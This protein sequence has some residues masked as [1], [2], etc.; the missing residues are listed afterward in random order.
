[1]ISVPS[2]SS[3]TGEVT[4]I[5]FGNCPK[6]VPVDIPSTSSKDMETT[7]NTVAIDTT[8]NARRH[9]NSAIFSVNCAVE[10][11]ALK[12]FGLIESRRPQTAEELVE[13]IKS[14]D[15]ILPK[16]DAEDYCEEDYKY[17]KFLG[18][19]F[20]PK[21]KRD[22]AGFDKFMDDFR[23]EKSSLELEVQVLEPADALKNF[24]KFESRWIN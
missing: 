6:A 12:K 9:I 13:W 16:V 14:D 10:R 8:L 19:T 23:K 5:T 11:E 22:R 15:F 17:E 18:L 24:K 4:Y 2:I 3:L 21:I 7:M 20:P 1:M